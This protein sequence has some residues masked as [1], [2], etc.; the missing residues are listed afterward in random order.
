MPDHSSA[1]TQLDEVANELDR[2]GDVALAARARAA[3]TCLRSGAIEPDLLSS[4]EAAARLGVR[5]INTVKRWAREGLLDGFQVGGRV[6][7]S[8]AS[9]ERMLS[10]AA[11]TQERAN[12]RDLADVLE[13]FDIG[14]EPLPPSELPH[15]GRAPWDSVD[16]KQP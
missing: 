16:A 4:T 10:S 9:V 12:E 7:V 1:L 8:R 6:K 13:A 15:L 3:V 2:R 14:D 5:S 11:L